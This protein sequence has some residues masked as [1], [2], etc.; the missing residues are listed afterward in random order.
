M[1]LPVPV[2][3]FYL[4]KIAVLNLGVVAW[5]C[6]ASTQ[7]AEAGGLQPG[8]Q[9]QLHCKILSWRPALAT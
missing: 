9:P 1:S 3:S 8:G 4:K 7:E 6:S 2:L 5:A